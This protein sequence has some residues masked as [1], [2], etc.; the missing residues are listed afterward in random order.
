MQLAHKICLVSKTKL[1]AISFNVN[2]GW[3]GVGLPE[4]VLINI[5][6][7]D[8]STSSPLPPAGHPCERAWQESRTH[9]DILYRPYIAIAV[10]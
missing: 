1:N 6:P 10:A 7:P 2:I 3:Y 4:H 5:I 8:R 9:S